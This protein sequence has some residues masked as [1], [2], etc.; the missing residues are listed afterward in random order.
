VKR[1]KLKTRLIAQ[2]LQVLARTSRCW[3]RS[4]V[5]LPASA[6]V[7]ATARRCQSID[8]MHA[9]SLCRRLLPA[10]ATELQWQQ[11]GL[12]QQQPHPAA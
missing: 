7:A 10:S 4:I 3:L 9:L 5:L 6:W 11:L 12:Q 2:V 8:I 1:K